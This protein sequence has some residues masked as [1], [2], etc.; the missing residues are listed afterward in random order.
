MYFSAQWSHSIY[1]L[2]SDDQSEHANDHLVRLNPDGTV[3]A[4]GYL[5]DRNSK[6]IYVFLFEEILAIANGPN[7]Y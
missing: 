7:P 3:S 4:D 5:S 2:I 6:Y 1:Q